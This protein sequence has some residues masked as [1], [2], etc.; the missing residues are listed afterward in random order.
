[1]TDWSHFTEDP[2]FKKFL[3][4]LINTH[5]VSH[6]NQFQYFLERFN[7]LNAWG[8]EVKRMIV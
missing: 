6:P 8:N 7:I 5:Q 3:V 4:Y 2:I 1:M